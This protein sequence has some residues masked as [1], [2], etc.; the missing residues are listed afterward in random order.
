MAGITM[1]S[2]VKRFPDGTVAVDHVSLEI[3][4]GEVFVLVGPSGCG[5]STLLRMV[6]GL[7][8]VSGGTISIGERVVNELEPRHRDI[9]MV[10][11]DYALY[12]HLNVYDN[13]AFGLRRRKW[14]KDQIDGR[15]REVARLLSI[16]ELVHRRPGQLSGAVKG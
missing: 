13:L 14:P 10:F 12:P 4:D 8:D 7:A 16:E 6:A 11:Q 9:A 2:V 3:P 5:K 15:V 1:D